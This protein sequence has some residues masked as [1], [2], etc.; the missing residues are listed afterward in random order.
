MSLRTILAVR[1]V[2]ELFC[3]RC[4]CSTRTCKRR[5]TSDVRAFAQCFS[6]PLDDPAGDV[7]CGRII[8]LRQDGSGDTRFAEPA[9]KIHPRT[10]SHKPAKMLAATA[11]GM[12]P[13]TQ[14]DS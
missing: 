11:G 4:I 1:H 14:V 2:A 9:D 5:A 13:L 12:G 6:N 8:A 10:P 7:R 3:G